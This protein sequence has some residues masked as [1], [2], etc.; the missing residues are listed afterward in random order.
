MSGFMAL[1]RALSPPPLPHL[2]PVPPRHCARACACQYVYVRRGKRGKDTAQPLAA[3]LAAEVC[4]A[5]CSR[6][7]ARR[8]SGLCLPLES[9]APVPPSP[10]PTSIRLDKKQMPSEYLLFSFSF[11]HQELVC[12]FFPPLSRLSDELLPL[13]LLH[14]QVF[15]R[16]NKTGARIPGKIPDVCAAS[17]TLCPTHTHA[18]THSHI[19][20]LATV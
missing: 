16:G 13:L 4:S 17:P 7:E 9:N 12:F 15:K 1:C 6:I 2:P 18:Q 11:L 19:V 3:T 5:G 20:S 14:F 8:P 10:L